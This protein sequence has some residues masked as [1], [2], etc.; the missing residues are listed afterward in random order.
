VSDPHGPGGYRDPPPRPAPPDFVTR[1]ELDIAA[2]EIRQDARATAKH[3]A[4]RKFRNVALAALTG[5][6]V[7]GAATLVA[8]LLK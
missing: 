6:L 7:G 8:H 5:A 2:S 3:Y 4:D 1:R